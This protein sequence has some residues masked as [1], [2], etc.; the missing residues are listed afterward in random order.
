MF[1]CAQFLNVM[2]R[3]FFQKLHYQ[4]E[5]V[6]SFRYLEHILKFLKYSWLL[7]NENNLKVLCGVPDIYRATACEQPQICRVQ[8]KIFNLFSEI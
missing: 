6:E 1:T 5:N 2:K 8:Q 7:K 3:D 4:I